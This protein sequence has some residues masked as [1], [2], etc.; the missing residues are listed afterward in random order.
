MDVDDVSPMQELFGGLNS[1][2]S[3]VIRRQQQVLLPDPRR[4]LV[5]QN[6]DYQGVH[7]LSRCARRAPVRMP[8]ALYIR[9]TG[10][11][12]EQT[13]LPSVTTLVGREAIQDRLIR[14]PLQV[15]I[16]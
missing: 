2:P 10:D 3:P 9:P 5:G 11:N 1:G 8:K 13:P 16:E 6:A 7:V 12:V 15:E 14:G 4:N